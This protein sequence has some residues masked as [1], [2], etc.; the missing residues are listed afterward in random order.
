MKQHFIANELSALLRKIDVDIKSAEYI[1]EHGEEY[2]VIK[3][4]N[5]Y[6]KKVCVT[7]DSILAIAKDV[8]KVI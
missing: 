2:V 1:T 7:A 5:G 6:A 4:S 8:L 3:F